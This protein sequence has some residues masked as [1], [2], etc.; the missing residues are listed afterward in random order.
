V[1]HYLGRLYPN[2]SRSVMQRAVKEGLVRLNGLETKPGHRLRVNDCLD[3]VLPE[4]RDT[5]IAPEPIDLD[6]LHEDDAIVVL[7][8]PAGLIVHPGRGNPTGTLAA[9]LQH[10]FDR[11]SDVAGQY[12]P[13]IVHRLDRDTSGVLVVAKDNQVH[14]KLSAQF[15][16]RTVAKQYLA[17]VK[18]RVEFDSDWVETFVRTHPKHREKMI[19]CEEGGDARIA[20]TFYEVAD[21]ADGYSVVRL[22]PK[23]GRTHQLRIHMKHIGHVIAADKLYGG[24]EQITRGDLDKHAE[25]ADEVLIA[26]QA[27]HARVLEFDHPRTGARVRFEAPPPDDMTRLINALKNL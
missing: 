19:V 23:T 15:E 21:R 6:V 3:V 1:D 11:L 24:A 25:N 8:K 5:T 26:R 18:G 7:N 22:F 2:F 4:E 9:G 27:L 16:A 17:V 14:G 12:R 10:H 13:G 20:T